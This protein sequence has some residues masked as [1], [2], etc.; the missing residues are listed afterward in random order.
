MRC[1]KRISSTFSSL[2][3]FSGTLSFSPNTVN[4]TIMAYF[5]AKKWEEGNYSV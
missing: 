5:L 2:I 1:A 3:F 4:N